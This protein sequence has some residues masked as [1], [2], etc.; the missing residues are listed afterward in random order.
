ML[1]S[2]AASGKTDTGHHQLLL[3]YMRATPTPELL[4]IA[5]NYGQV[6]FYILLLYRLYHLLFTYLKKIYWFFFLLLHYVF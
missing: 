4:D 3:Q 6:G 2:T 5:N 1:A